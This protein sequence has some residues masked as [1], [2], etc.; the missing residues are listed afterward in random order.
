M[1][2]QEL[3]AHRKAS[4]RHDAWEVLPSI[5]VPTLVLHGE[6]DLM[7]P[8]ENARL[9]SDRIP[10]AQLH[11]YP[12]SRHGFFEEFSPQVTA[13]VIEFLSGSLTD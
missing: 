6:D 13:A 1:N 7:T 10:G 12:G 11:V 9:L 3:A 4:R 2:Q 5:A 8:V